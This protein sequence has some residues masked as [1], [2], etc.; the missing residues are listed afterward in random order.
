MSEQEKPSA[1][2][3]AE[4]SRKL[5][6]EFLRLRAQREEELEEEAYWA[7]REDT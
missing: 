4:Q 5:A 7:T 3:L 2:E 6:R 1:E